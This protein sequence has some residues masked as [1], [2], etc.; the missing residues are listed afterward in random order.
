MH[1][2]KTGWVN[3]FMTGAKPVDSKV[4][5]AEEASPN[6]RQDHVVG[7]ADHLRISG[8]HIFRS[9]P[10][11]SVFDRAYVAGFVVNYRYHRMPLLDGSS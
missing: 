1:I 2:P 10:F 4:F 9:K 11:Q 8:Q 7:A 6:S 3:D 5:M